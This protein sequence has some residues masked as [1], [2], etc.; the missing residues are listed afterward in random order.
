MVEI[1]AH[2]IN[3]QTVH[4]QNRLIPIDNPATG[5]I[6]ANI[7][8]ANEQLISEAVNYAKNAQVIWSATPALKRAQI[9]RTFAQ[10]IESE[11]DVLAELVTREHGKTLDDAKASIKRGLEVLHYHC[12]IPQQLQGLYS[13]QVSQNTHAHT[14]FQPLG[15]CVGVAPFNFP[16]MVPMWMMVP[17]IACGN[18]FILKPSEKVPSA[19]LQLVRWF[20]QAGLPKGLLQCI[21]GDATTV[22]SLL[23]HPDIQ[24]YTA[25]GST[26]AAN[27]IYTEATRQGKRAHTFGGAKNHALVMPDANITHAAHQIVNAAYGSAGQRCMAISVVVCVGDETANRLCDQMQPLIQKIKIGNGMEPGIDMGPVISQQQKESLLHDIQ[28]GLAEGAQ[29]LI[30][31]RDRPCPIEGYFLGPSLFDHVQPHMHI[32]QKELFGPILVMLRVQNFEEAIQLI[33]SHRYG[34]GGVIFTNSGLY[35]EQFSNAIEC[36]MIGVNIPIPVPIVSHPFGGWKQSSFGDRP[37]HALESIHFYTQQ[38]T[39]TTTWPQNHDNR[40]SLSMP[41]H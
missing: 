25:V 40:I 17:A 8:V 32:Y 6:I 33:N 4:T 5:K 22:Q 30:D 36:G 2:H 16:V 11:I 18:A 1:I 12:N 41:S 13:H 7:D 21:Q 38:K 27:Y 10:K 34:N 24:A 35:A 31:G 39:I 37:M 28:I 14:L 26:Q 23:K 29:L 19:A 3:G 20:E 9:L 15:V